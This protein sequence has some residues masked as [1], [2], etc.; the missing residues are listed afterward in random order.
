MSLELGCKYADT[1]P[2]SR[3]SWLQLPWYL[4]SLELECGS[5]WSWA[6]DKLVLN[7][8]YYLVT[9]FSFQA[10]FSA[11]CRRAAGAGKTLEISVQYF[12]AGNFPSRQN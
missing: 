9:C 7:S 1:F 3:W 11:V 4:S 10:C 5:R 8:D 2:V 6:T 12:L